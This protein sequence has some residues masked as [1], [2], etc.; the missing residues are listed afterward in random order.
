MVRRLATH[1]GFQAAN[2][3]HRC[4]SILQLLIPE[5]RGPVAAIQ[6]D[7]DGLLDVLRTAPLPLSH[8]L[9]STYRNH[10]AKVPRPGFGGT[11]ADAD[12]TGF[13]SFAAVAAAGGVGH[14]LRLRSEPS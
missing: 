1:L 5:S 2:A 13:Q 10:D 12:R 9:P 6:M 11:Q 14:H 4:Q 3:S 8:L 7:G